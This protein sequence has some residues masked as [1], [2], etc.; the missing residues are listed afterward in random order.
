MNN[1]SFNLQ[2]TK[3]IDGKARLTEFRGVSTS[4]VNMKSDIDLP[5]DPIRPPELMRYGFSNP[6]KYIIYMLGLA[7]AHMGKRKRI[8]S[9]E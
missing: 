3:Y 8:F 7:V 4:F 1:S 6:D 9:K 5:C 2:M